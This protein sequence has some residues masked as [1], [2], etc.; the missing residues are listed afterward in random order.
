MKKLRPSP[1]KFG[2]TFERFELI[3]NNI[4]LEKPDSIPQFATRM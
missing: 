1:S 4:G 3:F 2:Q